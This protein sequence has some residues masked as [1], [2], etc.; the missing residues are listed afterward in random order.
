MKEPSQTPADSPTKAELNPELDNLVG[1]EY[2][3]GFITDIESD[4][5]PPGLDEDVVRA[6]SA[7]KGEPKFMLNYRLAA[8]RQWQKMVE[9]EWAQVDLSLIHI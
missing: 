3:E 6:I 7:K 2:K 5:F 8:F 1:R 4:T 9:P